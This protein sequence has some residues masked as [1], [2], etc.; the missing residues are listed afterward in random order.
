MDRAGIESKSSRHQG[1]RKPS[2]SELET[3]HW[4]NLTYFPYAARVVLKRTGREILPRLGRQ[5][6]REIL[7]EPRNRGNC[8]VRAN[9]AFESS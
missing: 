6:R 7:C 1:L 8:E 4:I 5:V 2:K 3:E 9:E